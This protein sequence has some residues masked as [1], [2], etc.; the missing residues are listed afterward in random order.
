M[1]IITSILD[2]ISRTASVETKEKSFKGTLSLHM[3][4]A[5]FLTNNFSHKNK[6]SRQSGVKVSLGQKR[7]R[8]VGKNV[9]TRG[10]RC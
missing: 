9:R 8:H 5:L 10:I 1:K 3:M 2:S 4:P 6:I 7:G